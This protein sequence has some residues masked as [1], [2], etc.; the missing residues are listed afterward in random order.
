MAG[1]RRAAPVAEVAP[2][3]AAP[4]DRDRYRRPD[5]LVAAL[6]FSPGARI[7]DVGAGDGYLT[8]RLAARAGV[9]G[10]VV[11]TDIDRAALAHIGGSR[12]GEAPIAVQI[13]TPD[14][15]GLETAFFDLI[16]LSEVDHYLPDRVAYL[17][18]LAAA[19]APGGRIAI[20]NR[21]V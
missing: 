6:H 17:R 18:K 16:L 4:L 8:H 21:R 3:P 12:P 1:C 19:L 2:A 9:H 15:P 5:L 7:A 10:D 14:D 11:A 13:V 20:C